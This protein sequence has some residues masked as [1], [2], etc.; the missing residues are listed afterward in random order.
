[1]NEE[2]TER[3]NLTKGRNTSSQGQSRIRRQGKATGKGGMTKRRKER[4][5][6]GEG[7]ELFII[8]FVFTARYCGEGGFGF[9]VGRALT[10]R[11]SD[12]QTDTTVRE[13]KRKTEK[14][15]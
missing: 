3:R 13:G 2:I 14:E 11:Q 15:V 8:E 9:F 6:G 7:F 1:M 5:F 10:H 4:L 12:R